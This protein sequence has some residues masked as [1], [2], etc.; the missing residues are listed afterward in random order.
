MFVFFIKTCTDCGYFEDLIKA[1]HRLLDLKEKYVDIDVLDALCKSVRKNLTDPNDVSIRKY[2]Q[3]ILELFGRITSLVPNEW[4]VYWF[5]ADIVLN[6][7][8]NHNDDANNNDN[9]KL[10]E[11]LAEKYFGLLQKAFRNLYNQTNWELSVEKC[12]EM[13]DYSTQLL[14]SDYFIRLTF[15]KTI[16]LINLINLTIKNVTNMEVV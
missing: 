9:I 10:D 1:Y 7:S 8:T 5:Y 13:V 4:K 6:L 2:K 15:Y 16:H 12:K 11:P 3:K 14:T